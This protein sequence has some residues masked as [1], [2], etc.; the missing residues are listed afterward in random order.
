MR[1][2]A[3]AL[4]P[5]SLGWPPCTTSIP[6]PIQCSLRSI[7]IGVRM[8]GMIGIK[9]MVL[10][11]ELEAATK[12]RATARSFHLNMREYILC[13][14]ERCWGEKLILL[15]VSSAACAASVD[16]GVRVCTAHTHACRVGVRAQADSGARLLPAS[17][18]KLD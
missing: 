13:L 17:A 18:Q 4:T 5:H 9:G 16:T 7:E 11:P 1:A 8:K 6:Q 15:D 12:L 3:P 14:R 2:L 10:E